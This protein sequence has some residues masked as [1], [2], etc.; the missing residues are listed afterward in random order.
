MPKLGGR[1]KIIVGIAVVVLILVVANITG[2]SR[3]QLSF[4]ERAVQDLLAPIKSGATYVYEKIS[5]IPVYIGG[6]NEIVAEN[7]RLKSEVMQLRDR[8]GVL[9]AAQQENVRLHALLDIVEEMHDWTPVTSRIIGRDGSSWY[10]TVTITGGENMGFKKDMPVI[11]SEGLVGRIISVSKYSSE[12]LLLIDKNGAVG[13]M[14]QASGTFG[15]VQSID[16]NNAILQLIHIP[17]DAILEQGQVIV[18]SG[19]GGV[20]PAG[21]RIGYVTGTA[22]SDGGL[23]Q[24][25]TITPFVDFER[26]REV[27]VLTHVPIEETVV[28]AD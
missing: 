9:E 24:K 17:Y 20:F 14:I 10:N 4:L 11:N 13:A 18:T 12:V 3:G 16:E 26:L 5:Y 28:E 2:P 19:L 6:V 1:G 25:A 8:L 27:L 15:V 21:L 22:A 7:E 23:M